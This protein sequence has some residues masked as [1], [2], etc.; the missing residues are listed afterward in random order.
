MQ[1]SKP[2]FSAIQRIHLCILQKLDE[3]LTTSGMPYWITGGTL[4]GAI[5]HVGFVPHDDNVDIECFGD[6]FDRMIAAIPV[7]P[8]FYTGFDRQGGKWE[9]HVSSLEEFLRGFAT[10]G[11]IVHVI[12]Y[13]V[14]NA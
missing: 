14:H 7:E 12:E 1:M 2:L 3:M 13:I 4:I 11:M 6:D 9:G 5:Q 10:F 8:P